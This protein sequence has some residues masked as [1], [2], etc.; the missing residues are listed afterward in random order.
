MED[1]IQ[2]LSFC[3]PNKLQ[4]ETG[5][6]GNFK[7]ALGMRLGERGGSVTPQSGTRGK[8]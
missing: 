7:K 8:E 5:Y 3:N 2:L 4:K 6:L 1:C